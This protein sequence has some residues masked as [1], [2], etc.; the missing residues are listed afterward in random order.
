VAEV[1]VKVCPTCYLAHGNTTDIRDTVFCGCH[2]C[3]VS[4][5]G[6]QPVPSRVRDY[7]NGKGAIRSVQLVPQ[8]IEIS[9]WRG[10]GYRLVQTFPER[11]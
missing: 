11:R 3:A 2:D 1:V 7:A 5:L 4:H 9:K 10:I 8:G 6:W